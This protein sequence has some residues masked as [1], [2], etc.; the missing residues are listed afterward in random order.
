MWWE[1]TGGLIGT[2]GTESSSELSNKEITWSSGRL[3]G[4]EDDEE[5]AR[6]KPRSIDKEGL[7][8]FADIVLDLEIEEERNHEAENKSCKLA[9]LD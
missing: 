6:D 7:V 5:G 9:V 3:T 2:E 4:R 1:L 8:E